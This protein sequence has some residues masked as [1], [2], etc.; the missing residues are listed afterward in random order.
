MVGSRLARGRA[1][2][3]QRETK[4]TSGGFDFHGAIGIS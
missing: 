3:E 4:Q 1:G 2:G